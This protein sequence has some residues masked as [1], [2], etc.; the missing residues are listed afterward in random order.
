MERRLSRELLDDLPAED[1][2]AIRG[3][4]D[5]RRLNALMRH[6]EMLT[7]ALCSLSERE[8]GQRQIVELGAGDGTLMLRVAEKLGFG[9]SGTTITLLDQRSVVQTET[10]RSFRSLGWQV[11]SET[12]EVFDW[13]QRTASSR[14][15]VVVCNLFLHHFSNHGLRKL[16]GFVA[17]RSRAIIALEPRRGRVPLFFSR[18]VGLI[19][20][21][22]VTRH[23]AVASVRAGFAAQDLS[24]LWPEP[25]Y[26]KIEERCARHTTHLFIARR[27]E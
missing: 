22:G 23:D 14:C 27:I 20:C 18:F 26:W 11:R 3:R 4:K 24:T 25:Q 1:P 2:R 17:Q 5:L 16:L 7:S 8:S 9:W 6:A 12:A 15:E 10:E 13:L 21:D 19:G